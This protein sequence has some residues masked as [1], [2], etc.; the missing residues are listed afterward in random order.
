MF[1][2]G[3]S[4]S[5]YVLAALDVVVCLIATAHVL[6]YK[7]DTRAATGWIGLIWLSP[8]VGAALYLLLGV[9]RISRKAHALRRDPARAAGPPTGPDIERTLA[10]A[11]GPGGSHLATLGHV[12]DQVARF[13]LLA[14]NDVEVLVGGDEAYPAML[15]AIDAATRTIALSTYIFDRDRAGKPFVDALG[16]AVGRGVEVRVLIDDFGSRHR[17]PSV[18]RPLRRAGVPVARFL[19]TLAPRWFPYLNLRNHRKILVVDGCLG[20]TGGMNILED[21]L[22]GVRPRRPKR[23]LHF[24]VR[25]PAVAGLWHVFAEDWAHTT[26]EDLF[27]DPWTPPAE[28]SG[29]MFARVVVEGP[30]D[31]RDPLVKV[32]LGAL[33]CA[34]SSVAIATPYFLP[35]ARLVSAFETA[36]LRGVEVDVLIP[37]R[38]N[39]LLVQWAS[40]AAVREV[41]EGR[42]RV[43]ASPPPFDHTKLMVVDRAWSLVGSAN[44]D[45]RSLRL[46]F[47][48]D[49]ECYSTEFAARLNGLFRDRLRESVP[50]TA[51]LIDGRGLVTRLRDGAARLLTPYL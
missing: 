28:A 17:W 48:L 40:V 16:R 27:H 45:A 13:P 36:A 15:Q 51:D 10:A 9:N 12:V 14:G 11:L 3:S 42:C 20:F 1:T 46:N 41:L 25:G 34:R 29:G 24:R 7:R 21:Y 22:L 18:I 4:V 19:P 2:P 44:W 50:I 38:N 39:H 43:W 8:I 6:L 31:D 23:D 30:D 49:L 37:S 33:A 35:D 26:A 47:E 32:L 5:A